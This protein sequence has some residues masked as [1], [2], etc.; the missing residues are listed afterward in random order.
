[1]AGPAPKSAS[2]R[3]YLR[4]GLP[5]VYRDGDNR[6]PDRQRPFGMRFV[7]ALE[8]VLDPIVCLLDSLPQHIDPAL[9]P[10]DML[11]LLGMWLGLEIDD[12]AP[13]GQRRAMVRQAMELSRTRGTLAGLELTLRLTFPDL[14]LHVH[15]QGGVSWSAEVGA[16]PMTSP[17]FEVVSR[18]PLTVEERAAVERV[19]TRAKPA[20]VTHRTVVREADWP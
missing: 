1:M 4:G 11:E 7:Q 20:H 19:V 13:A 17:G 2:R 14:A 16:P 9:A 15:D 18:R 6:S 3:G 8:E 5:G 12:A 10:D